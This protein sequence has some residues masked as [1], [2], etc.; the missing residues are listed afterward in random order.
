VIGAG[1]TLATASLP[2]EVTAALAGVEY[3]VFEDDVTTDD[4]P[5]LFGQEFDGPMAGHAPGMPVHYDLHVWF[6]HDNPNGLFAPFNPALS[7]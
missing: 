7:C 2:L 3:L 5:S 1:I 4:P 6:W